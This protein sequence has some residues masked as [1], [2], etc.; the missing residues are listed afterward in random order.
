[1][2]MST[3]AQ[4]GRDTVKACISPSTSP[5]SPT[6]STP[7]AVSTRMIYSNLLVRTLVGYDH[8]AGGDG[9]KLVPDLAV[10]V[11]VS[12]DG[13]RRYA[14]TLKR[15]IKFGPPVNREIRSSDIRYAIERLAR[16]RN[17]AI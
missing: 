15:G 1:M 14:F 6:T 2:R 4:S 11:P 8:V 5:D 10:R 13:G 12:S 16:A 17:G 9:Y 7:A 3:T